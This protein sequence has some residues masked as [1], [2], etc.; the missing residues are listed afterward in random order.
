MW[1]ALSTASARLPTL[2]KVLGKETL[3]LEGANGCR[4]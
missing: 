1:G 4:H 2:V 3:P